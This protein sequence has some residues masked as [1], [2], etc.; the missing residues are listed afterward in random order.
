MQKTLK[1]DF[2]HPASSKNQLER[3][4]SAIQTG[5]AIAFPTDTFY[6]LGVDPFNEQALTRLFEIKQRPA[7]NPI[8]V[9][10]A[11]ESQLSQVTDKVSPQTQTL[12]DAFWPGPLTLVFPALPHLPERLTAGTGKIGVRLPDSGFTRQLISYLNTPLTAPSANISGKPEPQTVDD[13]EAVLVDGLDW[14]V[15]NGPTPG[16]QASTVLDPTTNP[17]TLIREGALSKEQIE[18]VLGVPCQTR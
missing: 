9:L 14:I 18:S 5:K 1:I 2:D 11:E 13:L 12:M 8:L 10:I 3:V 4:Q 17:V 6:G 7:S 16:G 15:D